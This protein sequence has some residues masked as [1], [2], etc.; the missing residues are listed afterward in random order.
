LLNWRSH[1]PS[2]THIAYMEFI[3]KSGRSKCI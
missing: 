2:F 3:N 1:L